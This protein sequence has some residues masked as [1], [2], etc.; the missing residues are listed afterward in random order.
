MTT[1]R[2]LA[3][4]ALF[5]RIS[6]A[7][8]WGNAPSRRLKMWTDVPASQRPAMFQF[9]GGRG[10]Y[11]WSNTAYAKRTIEARLFIYVASSDAQPGAPQL[12]AIQDAID[13]I[14]MPTGIDFATG[15]NTL[16]GTAYNARVKDVPVIDPGDLDGDGLLVIQI[17][18][19]LP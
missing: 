17:E 16:G 19:I 3:L 5:T 7:Y 4:E 2:E 11:A 14:M 6:G 1:P 12:T 9:E 13:T 18:I 10:S 15:R 8:A